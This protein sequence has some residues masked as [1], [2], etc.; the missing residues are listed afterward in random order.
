MVVMVGL[1]TISMLHFIVAI[2]WDMVDMV[3]SSRTSTCI[4][5]SSSSPTHVVISRRLILVVDWC[6]ML[7]PI[8]EVGH[9]NLNGSAF[10]LFECMLASALLS[11]ALLTGDADG[12]DNDEKDDSTHH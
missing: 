6:T 4:T 7:G 2:N 8:Q 1:G 3:G 11:L 9:L 10:I 12:D 5:N